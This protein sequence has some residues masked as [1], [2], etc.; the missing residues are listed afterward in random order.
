MS[1]ENVK[2]TNKNTNSSDR[3]SKKAQK[4]ENKILRQQIISS[5]S[6]AEYKNFQLEKLRY[7]D[8]KTSHK[9][10]YVGIICSLIACFLALNSVSPSAFLGGFGVVLAILLNIFILL[11][12]FLTVEKVKAYSIGYSKYMIGLGVVCA[13]RI[14]W[15]P[16]TTLVQYGKFVSDAK[17]GSSTWAD[18]MSRYNSTLGKSL[19]SGTPIDQNGNVIS[20]NTIL[21]NKLV[22]VDERIILDHVNTTGYLT[23][24]YTIR[25]LLMILFLGVAAACFIIGG[26]IGLKKS[27]MLKKYLTS[28]DKKN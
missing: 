16:L 14:L 22:P 12:G 19:L 6:E 25:G 9:L 27:I 1:N 8:N 17:A 7:F 10:G 18:L 2:L 28:L 3:K 21:N 20:N 5:M 24:N 15:Y 26:L 4:E 23:A 11:T 13:L